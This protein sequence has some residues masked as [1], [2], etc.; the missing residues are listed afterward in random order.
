MFGFRIDFSTEA[1]ARP[2]ARALRARYGGQAVEVCRAA[3]TRPELSGERRRI[4]RMALYL[5]N[6]GLA[7][8]ADRRRV[9]RPARLTERSTA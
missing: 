2:L 3:L 6:G 4:V 5:L 9:N 8:A 1:K 7:Q